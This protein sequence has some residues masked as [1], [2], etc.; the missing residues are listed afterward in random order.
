[1]LKNCTANL[2]DLRI[3]FLMYIR[4]SKSI[5]FSLKCVI[6]RWRAEKT[7]GLRLFLVNNLICFSVIKGIIVPI[8]DFVQIDFHVPVYYGCIEIED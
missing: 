2:V 6:I 8:S 3:T 4:T 5:F 7:G 1:M